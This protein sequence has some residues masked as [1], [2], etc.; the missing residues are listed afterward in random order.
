MAG[1]GEVRQETRNNTAALRQLT[2]EIRDE[3]RKTRENFRAQRERFF[4]LID[5]L[6][7]EGPEPA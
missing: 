7:G 2:R 6:W 3:M 4:R 1:L 5:E